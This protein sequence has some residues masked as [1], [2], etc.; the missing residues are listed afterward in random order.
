MDLPSASN[1][2]TAQKDI[3]DHHIHIQEVAL[4]PEKLRAS[5]SKKKGI[6]VV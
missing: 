4:E 6:I 5:S 3:E 1:Y 2:G